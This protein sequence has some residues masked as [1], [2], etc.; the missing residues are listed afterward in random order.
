[1]SE[2]ADYRVAV[3]ALCAFTARGGDLDLRFTPSPTAQEGMAGHGVVT[4]RRD[5]SYEREIALE[6]HFETLR[7][8]G[9]ADGFDPHANR[10]EEIKTFRGDLEHQPENHRRLHW[11][12]A[13]VYGALMCRA[14]ELARIELALVYFDVTSQRETVISES[15]EATALEAFFATQCRAFLA[16]AAQELAHRR[17]REQWL[18]QLGFPHDTFRHGQRALAENVYKA[19][20]TGR[21]LMAQA[22]TG[23]G[24]TLG[25]LFPMLKAMPGQQ[26]D[27]LC[28]LTSRTTGR[29][30]ALDALTTLGA[31]A[32]TTPLRALELIAREKACENPDLACHGDSCPLARGFYDRLPA[33]RQAAVEAGLLDHTTL[34]RVALAHEICPY[35]LGQ[36]MARWA[37]VLIGDVN[38]WFDASAML[39]ALSVEQQWRI[40]L[41][42]DEAHNLVERGRR[43]YSAELDQT[44]FLAM[45]RQ[46]PTALKSPLDRVAR[47]WRELNAELDDGSG[48]GDYRVLAAPPG[49]LLEALARAVSAINDYMVEQPVGLDSALLEFYFDALQLARV[50]ELFDEH[51]LCD[52][53]RVPGRAGRTASRL[54]LRNVVPAPLLAPRFAA[55]RSSVLFSA[56]LSPAHY[57]RDL[58]GLPGAT[59]WLEM[60]SPFAGDQLEL[61]VDAHISTRYRDRAASLAP[62]ARLIAAQYRKR[63]GNYLAFFSSFDYLERVVA[64]LREQAPELPLHVQSRR[65]SEQARRD[66]LA[67]FDEHQGV[68]GFAVLGGIFGEGIDL[69]GERLIGAF[70]ATLG[71]PQV[72]AVNEQMKAR[73]AALFGDGYRYTY[74]YPGLTKV[75]Q[76]AGRVIRTREDRG[77]I[78][79]IDDRFDRAE[80]RSLLPGWWSP[81]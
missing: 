14:R 10:L 25:T 28:F 54:C 40:G 37:D 30:L 71:L 44:R 31:S 81:A 48:D 59:P 22:P 58:L 18:A 32:P 34:R 60:A 80:V 66:F 57:Y 65:M 21:A 35:Y 17:A 9:R 52:L 39:Y 62:I 55:A 63:P 33:A 1:M 68:I 76:A 11:A 73:M 12:Q 15:F 61:H 49:R 2:A 8:R 69:P 51:F 47:R 41:M 7:V 13:K 53:T 45:R 16:W 23:I 77:V 26:L 4:A 43:M 74:L 19:V 3:R 29:Q 75:I 6:G 36:E 56:T 72:N 46:A 42:I 38:Y 70:I 50:H 24:K 5:A 27:R 64:T 67:V 78:H 79:L 20:A